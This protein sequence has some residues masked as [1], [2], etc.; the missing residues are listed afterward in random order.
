MQENTIDAVI[1]KN[2]DRSLVQATL[3]SAAATESGAQIAAITE[4][5]SAKKAEE[6][7]HLQQQSSLQKQEIEEKKD[8]QKSDS[9]SV[10]QLS[11]EKQELAALQKGEF[12]QS[13]QFVTVN[14]GRIIL[15]IKHIGELKDSNK[16]INLQDGDVL[17]IPEVPIYVLIK[18]AVFR[19]GALLIEENTKYKYYIDKVGGV[20]KTAL[21]D[22]I[23][24]IRNDG[25]VIQG[26]TN[27][28]AYVVV[29]GDTII[30]PRDL[31]PKESNLKV[32]TSV[33]DI[34]FKTLTSIAL[35]ILM[36]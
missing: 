5:R 7:K 2:E 27:L 8:T 36:F 3:A 21:S 35:I 6:E 25:T 24:I 30:V 20:R 19:E 22:Q 16:D 29:A 31:E 9:S 18:G 14:Q 13:K 11:E 34:I 4:I 12:E 32:T 26:E 1:S 28:K 10:D 15:E 17:H 23:H 33:V